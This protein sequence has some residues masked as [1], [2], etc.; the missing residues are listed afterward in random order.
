MHGLPRRN[1]IGRPH[2]C[3]QTLQHMS[4]L[5]Q[6]IE[7]RAPIR[8]GTVPGCRIGTAALL[9]GKFFHARSPQQRRESV[10]SFDAAGHPWPARSSPN[11]VE[12]S[13]AAKRRFYDGKWSNLPVST[14]W[15]ARSAI[16]R[17]NW[18]SRSPTADN[19][20][21]RHYPPRCGPRRVELFDRLHRNSDHHAI[22]L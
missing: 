10:V 18:S 5:S 12:K 21:W 7:T 16:R 20:Y 8:E 1:G 11:A 19:R 2:P 13:G 15:P 9:E 14:A 6:R 22:P 17:R 3:R 4:V